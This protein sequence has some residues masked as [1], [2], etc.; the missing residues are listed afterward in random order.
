M[1]KTKDDKIEILQLNVDLLKEMFSTCRIKDWEFVMGYVLLYAQHLN[2]KTCFGGLL[3]PEIKAE[4]LELPADEIRNGLILSNIPGLKIP[5]NRQHLG[6]WTV[7]EFFRKI[8]IKGVKRF[9]NESLYLWSVGQRYYVLMFGM[10][11]ADDVLAQMAEKRRCITVFLNVSQL[12]SEIY[13]PYVT[14]NPLEFLIHD[15]QHMEHFLTP[16]FFEEQLGFFRSCLAIDVKN[17]FGSLD[18]LFLKDYEHVISDM[19]A[20]APHLIKF[21]KAKLIEAVSR[22]NIPLD[23]IFNSVLMQLGIPAGSQVWVAAQRLCFNGTIEDDL[24]LR[25]YFMDKGRESAEMLI[26]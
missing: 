2:N 10:P 13:P 4:A 26:H 3:S 18:E 12:I 20:C 6:T 9:V 25:Q 21:L 17:T 5:G 14:R 23:P 19:N 11:E 8:S 22:Q 16:R 1:S 24:E 15:I 7:Q